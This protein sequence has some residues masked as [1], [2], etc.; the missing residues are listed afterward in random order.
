MRETEEISKMKSQT[1]PIKVKQKEVVITRIFEAPRELVWKA[2]T[3]PERVKR[4]WGPKVF[5]AP[6]IKIDLRVGGEH[7]Y[8]MR[9]PD[10]KDYWGKGVY[11]EIAPPERLVVTDSFA[12]EKGNV[13]P[14]TYYGLSVDTPLEMLVTVTFEELEGKTRMTLKHSGV[15]GMSDT[16][17]ANMKQGWMESFDK[18]AQYLSGKNRANIV[19]EPGKQEIVITREFDAPRDLV[20]KAFTDPELYAQWVGPRGLTTKLETFEPRNGSS[21]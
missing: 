7:L 15:A 1:R 11:G 14:A 13:V 18:L 17:Q 19:I 21:W 20:F 10:G 4:W 2:W 8:Y 9:A 6:F 16:E 3:E 12:D 5:T